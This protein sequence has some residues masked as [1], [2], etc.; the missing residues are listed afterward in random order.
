M[1]YQDISNGCISPVSP[2]RRKLLGLFWISATLTR[3]K[4]TDGIFQNVLQMFGFAV[5]VVVI[6]VCLFWVWALGG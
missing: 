5:V 1:F 3:M 2:G 6:V 4:N